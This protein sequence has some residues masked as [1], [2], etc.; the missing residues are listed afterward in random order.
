MNALGTLFYTEI[1]DYNQAAEWFKKASEKGCTRALNNLGVCYEQGHGVPKDYDQAFAL[2]KEAADK[3]YQEAMKNLGSLYF[4]N[5]RAT[6]NEAMFAESAKWFRKLQMLDP[7]SATPYFYLGQMHENGCGA[8]RDMK[9]AF[10]YYRR[11]AKLDHV[12]ALVKCGDF[13]YSGKGVTTFGREKIES[14]K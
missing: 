8:A 7:D 4:Q 11:A 10:Q 3:G 1:M 14:S 12:E 6:K 2:Y 5:A 9:S 13:I